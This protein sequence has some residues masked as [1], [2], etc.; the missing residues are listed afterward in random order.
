VE[1]VELEDGGVALA[2]V[3]PDGGEVAVNGL[4]VAL[5]GDLLAKRH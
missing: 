1:V 4:Y 2:V 3:G 5:P